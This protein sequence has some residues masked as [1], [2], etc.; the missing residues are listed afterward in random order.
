MFATPIF[1]DN[2][3]LEL[4]IAKIIWEMTNISLIQGITQN[5]AIKE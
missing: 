5:Y 4:D 3:N 2:Q 1:D